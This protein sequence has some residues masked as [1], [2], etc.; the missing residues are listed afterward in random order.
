MRLRF[1]S[2]RQPPGCDKRRFIIAVGRTANEETECAVGRSALSARAFPALDN[3]RPWVGSDA[4]SLGGVSGK[5]FV[6][7]NEPALD[8][9]SISAAGLLNPSRAP[10]ALAEA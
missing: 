5:A 3:K 8:G 6:T 4:V 9:F 7:R 2:A 10:P 1:D